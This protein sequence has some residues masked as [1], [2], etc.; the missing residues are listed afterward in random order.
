MKES[1]TSPRSPRRQV[2]RI[3]RTWFPASPLPAI[4]K[5]KR[6][7]FG[8]Q[9]SKVVHIPNVAKQPPTLAD[10]AAAA[11]CSCSTAAAVMRGSTR[12]RAETVAKVRSAAERINWTPLPRGG[13]RASVRR[14]A[15][16]PHTAG[17]DRPSGDVYLACLAREVGLACSTWLTAHGVPSGDFNSWQR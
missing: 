15:A 17:S 6:F 1:P 4:Q 16:H 8:A 13:S 11:G 3:N 2:A 10:L 9:I 12:F 5:R 7:A 14:Q